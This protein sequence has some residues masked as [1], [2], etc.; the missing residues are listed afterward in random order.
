MT[1]RCD[2]KGC[3]LYKINT[4]SPVLI[5]DS[6]FSL[7]SKSKNLLCDYDGVVPPIFFIQGMKIRAEQRK[8]IL[9]Y[10]SSIVLV[11]FF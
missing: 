11:N 9:L 7:T 3:G 8:L 2:P 1:V 4:E 10:V 5:R 6:V